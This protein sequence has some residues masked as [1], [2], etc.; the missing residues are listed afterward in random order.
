MAA[1]ADLLPSDHDAAEARGRSVLNVVDYFVPQE[2]Q[3]SI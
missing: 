1:A 3:S 2:D